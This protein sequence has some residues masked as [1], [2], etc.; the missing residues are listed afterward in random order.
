MINNPVGLL[1]D[2]VSSE[3][4]VVADKISRIAKE[5][6]LSTEFPKIVQAHP[7]LTGCRRFVPSSAVVSWIMAAL[8]RQDCRDPLDLNKLVL[9]DPGKIIS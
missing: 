7:V 5:S 8:L 2:H 9:T 6:D 4:N 1:T 3:E